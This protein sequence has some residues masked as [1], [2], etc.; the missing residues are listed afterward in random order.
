MNTKLTFYSGIIGIILFVAAS[1]LGGLLMDDYSIMSQYISE[2]YA[3]DST[4]GLPLRLL[5]FIPSGILLTIFFVLLAIYHNTSKMSKLG[6]YGTAIFYGIA[7]ILVGIFPCDSGCNKAL[8]APSTS[9]LIHNFA[10]AITYL[11]VP[12][13][14]IITGVGLKKA[15]KNSPLASQA[16][17]LGATNIVLI[18][19]LLSDSNS[20]FLGAY[21]R[22]V[23]LVFASWVICCA[24]DLKRH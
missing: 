15:D 10:G 21:Q 11:L 7:T 13:L 2:S 23:E 4:Y 20:P 16:I 19:L 22:I 5:G 3:I 14:M 12:V 6:F 18:F 9:Q 17:V 1:I 8:I 24:L